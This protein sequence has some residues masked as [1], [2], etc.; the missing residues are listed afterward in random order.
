MNDLTKRAVISSCEYFKEF[1]DQTIDTGIKA[2]NKMSMNWLSEALNYPNR[3]K[4]E[5]DFKRY[6]NTTYSDYIAKKRLT[7]ACNMLCEEKVSIKAV[8]LSCGF[9]NSATF[10]NAFKRQ[11][12]LAPSVYRVDRYKQRV[13][14]GCDCS[15][16]KRLN[17]AA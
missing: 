13:K 6:L 2:G 14:Q 7:L 5:R 4:L 3:K 9:S 10:C 12:G 11:F 1:I 8:A 17:S 15:K 16:E